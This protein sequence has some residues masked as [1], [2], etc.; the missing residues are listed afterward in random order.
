MKF[1]SLLLSVVICF[2]FLSPAFAQSYLP[3]LILT[4]K[5]GLW[6]DVRAYATL[7]DAVTAIGASE[8]TLV[9]P[10]VVTTNSVTIPITTKL[11]FTG[12][13]RI[14]VNPGQTLTLNTFWIEASGR[15]VFGST[16]SVDFADGSRVRNRW[17]SSLTEALAET[18]DDKVTL[19][20]EGAQS[21]T[22]NTA[23]GNDVVLEVA[24]GATITCGGGVTLSNV[25]SVIAGRYQIF[26]GA[27]DFDF[28]DGIEL[29]TDWFVSLTAATTFIG[30]D[31]VRLIFRD[32]ETSAVNITFGA[33]TSVEFLPG[34][35]LTQSAN[36]AT[37]QN[38]DIKGGNWTIFSGAGDFDF[39]E[40][41]ELNSQWFGG[42]Y[43]TESYTDDDNVDVV[44]MIPEDETLTDSVTF[45]EY[46]V[47][48]FRRGA[49]VTV[50]TTKVL[51]IY[52]PENVIADERRQI[53][54]AAGTG[55]VNFTLPGVMHIGWFGGDPGGVND[56]SGALGLARDSLPTEGGTI[57]FSGG[58]YHFTSGVSFGAQRSVGLRGI[59]TME[60]NEGSKNG[61]VLQS[62][63][64]ITL[65][66]FD[67]G[68]S[69]NH[70]GPVIENI[71]FIDSTGNS[72]TLLHI[73]L[74]VRYTVRNCRFEDGA[75]GAYI[76]DGGIVGGDA[77]WG[78]WIQNHFHST[79]TGMH[80]VGG[81]STNIY[82]GEFTGCTTGIDIDNSAN[83][84][85]PNIRVHG[86]KFD[87]TTGINT[88]GYTSSFIGC[89][90]ENATTGIVINGDG[91]TSRSGDANSVIACDFTQN[92]TGITLGA[93]STNT[94]LIGNIKSGGTLL[95]DAGT[96]L[97][98]FD[99]YGMALRSGNPADY[100]LDALY[101]Y[102]NGR[103]RVMSAASPFLS[104]NNTVGAPAVEWRLRSLSN[105]SL[106]F[107]DET[108]G[109]AYLN[110]WPDGTLGFTETVTPVGA[111]NVAMLYAKDNG[112][113]KTQL[114]AKFQGGAE[115]C[116]ATEP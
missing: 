6:T 116:F 8:A 20:V 52:S 57:Q 100:E 26:S 56:N 14:D 86:A 48:S 12:P 97:M 67:G 62:A 99:A 113:G 58:V 2:F 93:N 94:T 101:A 40:G 108:G 105:G 59:P 60:Y 69:I 32:D 21:V 70:S 77:S 36:T 34:S 22:A 95:S 89:G 24:A 84:S 53:F 74:T 37:F 29:Y 51:G 68:A 7:A 87:S 28:E 103:L 4:D 30:A 44:V 112:A 38:I 85:S 63:G 15:Q 16:G 55:E 107:R 82:G 96:G 19:L 43:E 78:M 80:I 92:V 71:A 65:I 42:L 17:F 90:F 23:V 88:Q 72:A 98:R 104:I 9:I 81:A 109:A 33:N 106:Q 75:K 102:F 114:C 11:K 1:R 45:D 111:V 91:V 110:L 25:G 18:S 66:T 76:Y 3:D 10:E 13:G 31:D 64:A 47:L 35:S 27:G 39:T 50:P 115:Q 49:V 46:F 73:E 54:T 5:T 79:T 41:T 61:T 83:Y